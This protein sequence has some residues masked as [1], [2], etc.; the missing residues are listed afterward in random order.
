MGAMLCRHRAREDAVAEQMDAARAGD[1]AAARLVAL[2]LGPRSRLG[3][4]HAFL[5]VKLG[6]ASTT[7]EL[8]LLLARDARR[9][10]ARDADDG[11]VLTRMSRTL[12]ARAAEF[13]D[14]DAAWR[15]GDVRAAARAGHVKAL[16]TRH[17]GL[18][19]LCH[20]LVCECARL[21]HYGAFGMPP[22]SGRT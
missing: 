22:G 7:R 9:V 20:P 3:L 14:A 15:L 6:D 8:A 21:R 13:G 10:G 2:R 1:A 12:L 11:V 18:T 17:P 19:H 5:A 4:D 16:E